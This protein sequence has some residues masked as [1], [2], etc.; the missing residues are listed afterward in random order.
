VTLTGEKKGVRLKRVQLQGGAE[1]VL[2]TFSVF[3]SPEK[4]WPEGAYVHGRIT[5]SVALAKATFRRCHGK[6]GPLLS[7][8]EVQMGRPRKE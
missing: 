8:G 2:K 4:K 3:F 1:P 5:S 6:T 7:T